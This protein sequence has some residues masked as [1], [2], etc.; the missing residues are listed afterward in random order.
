[1]KTGFKFTESDTVSVKLLFFG[2]KVSEKL[3][4]FQL[5]KIFKA[6]KKTVWR[7]R[8]RNVCI[9]F[10]CLQFPPDWDKVKH[11][12]VFL[13]LE[14]RGFTVRKR[15]MKIVDVNKA[16]KG[17]KAER[18]QTVMTVKWLTHFLPCL[19]QRNG[20]VLTLAYIIWRKRLLSFRFPPTLKSDSCF[21][22]T[23][24]ITRP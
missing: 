1:M 21:Y 6:E 10:I 2:R 16:L 18:D 12:S 13:F 23:S 14:Q 8:E 5:E 9:D 15:Q 19:S 20:L 11:L 3:L 4:K 22:K 17:F 24:S 7:E